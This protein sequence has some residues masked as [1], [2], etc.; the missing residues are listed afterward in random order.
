MSFDE[1]GE[2][3]QLARALWTECAQNEDA[4]R[5]LQTQSSLGKELVAATSFYKQRAELT[6][7]TDTLLPLAKEWAAQGS[8]A[9]A[10]EWLGVAVNSGQAEAE[11]EA[12]HALA[13][14][15]EAPLR[16]YVSAETTL[17]EHFAGLSPQPPKLDSHAA[18]LANAELAS[19][20]STPRARALSLTNIVDVFEPSATTD[21]AHTLRL[22]AGYNHLANQ[23]FDQARALFQAVTA[24]EPGDLAAWEGLV[25]CAK[26]VASVEQEATA[27]MQVGFLHGDVPRAAA[28]LRR[29][30]T[31]HLDEL[32]LPEPGYR[33]LARAVEL[34]IS[35]TPAFARLLKHAK[36]EQN[37]S[38]IIAL[39]SARL[40]VAESAK[41][42]TKLHWERARAYRQAGN[43]D[44]ALADLG[45]VGLLDPDHVG[46]K[47]LA[48]DIYISQQD[49]KSAA[50]ELSDLALLP[51]APAEQR[52]L[53]AITA[54]DLF[55]GK[56]NDIDAAL[57]VFN[58]ISEANLDL[59]PVAERLVAACAKAKRWEETLVLSG[60]LATNLPTATGRAEAAR[61]QLAVYRDELHKPERALN[62]VETLLIHSPGDAE[63][64]DTLLDGSLN[65]EVSRRLLREHLPSILEHTAQFAEVENLERLARIADELGDLELR[66]ATLGALV[67]RAGTEADTVREID[68]LLGH[69]ASYPDSTSPSYDSSLLVHE[70]EDGPLIE[71]LRLLAPHLSEVFGPTVSSL[72]SDGK[73]DVGPRSHATSAFR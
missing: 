72:D 13:A 24:E 68:Q 20:T 5:H 64:V 48:G 38:H 25:E 28:A 62:S 1:V 65:P 8:L 67:C 27:L 2:A 35:D 43:L 71:I 4:I 45:N 50:A 42:L 12:R 6:S 54:I 17:L 57:E 22:M 23:D 52:R 19:P 73:S 37:T 46:A 7:A 60:Y 36:S 29:A 30:A 41:E 61:L 32:A 44:Q 66:L 49:Y 33:C 59:L 15:L 21:Y 47:A 55:E 63:A 31:L 51:N 70:D 40:S 34:D 69:T 58:R 18:K 3:I 10:L 9:A 56:L 14:A 26:G 39:T 16:D 11:V 53:G